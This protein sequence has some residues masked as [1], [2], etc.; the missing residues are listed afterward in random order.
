[1]PD[2][3]AKPDDGVPLNRNR[4][5]F[6]DFNVTTLM[7][8]LTACDPSAFLKLH[9]RV[10]LKSRER[11]QNKGAVQ[12]PTTYPCDVEMSDTIPMQS[13]SKGGVATY[14]QEQCALK[15][16][17]GKGLVLPVDFDTGGHFP[18]AVTGTKCTVKS[19][20]DKSEAVL[21]APRRAKLYINSNHSYRAATARQD[22]CDF[23][24]QL[25]AMFRK[26]AHED[27]DEE[28]QEGGVKIQ[29]PAGGTAVGSPTRRRL[30]IKVPEPGAQCAAEAG[31]A[32]ARPTRD[33]RRLG[34]PMRVSKRGAA[35]KGSIPSR[36][37]SSNGPSKVVSG[38][39]APIAP[40]LF[41]FP[42]PSPAE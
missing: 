17:R 41:D 22:G 25:H 5:R 40:Q 3:D 8:A 32:D 30:G 2:P 13:R 24:E 31:G 34:L 9:F 15:G 21:K 23:C 29:T 11:M 14:I 12:Q 6:D 4:S 39:A 38:D 18:T 37:G 33:G 36:R 10:L 26:S 20:V 16:S 27:F 35:L 7:R 28:G 42:L 1:G 19:I